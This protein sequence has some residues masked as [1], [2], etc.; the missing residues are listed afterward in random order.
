MTSGVGCPGCPGR[1]SRGVP[2]RALP[3]TCLPRDWDRIFKEPM[4]T[5]AAIDRL[6]HYAIILEMTGT[7][8]RTEEAKKRAE[9]TTT[10]AA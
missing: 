1:V 7:S 5:A 3:A 8:F 2:G 4:T 10:T 6:I 9:P